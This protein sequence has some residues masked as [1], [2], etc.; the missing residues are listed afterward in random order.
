MDCCWSGYKQLFAEGQ[1]FT[2][3]LR[4]IGHYYQDYVNLMNHWDDVL[5]GFV[6]RVNNEDVID[7]LEGQVKESWISASYLLKMRA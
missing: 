4:D 3:D 5:P 6:L 2:Y 7:D 1:E